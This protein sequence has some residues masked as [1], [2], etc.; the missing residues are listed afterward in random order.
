MFDQNT[1]RFSPSHE[2]SHRRGD[3]QINVQELCV[4]QVCTVGV[5]DDDTDELDHTVQRHILEDPEGGGERT[6]AL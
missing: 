1:P 6:S 5:Q 2:N 3:D 4:S